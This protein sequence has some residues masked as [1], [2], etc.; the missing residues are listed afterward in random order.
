M[1]STDAE[2]QL[3]HWNVAWSAAAAE[4]KNLDLCGLTTQKTCVVAKAGLFC[5]NSLYTPVIVKVINSTQNFLGTRLK[6]VQLLR[7]A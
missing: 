5:Q 4:Q 2:E 3:G 6:R 1:V 7:R